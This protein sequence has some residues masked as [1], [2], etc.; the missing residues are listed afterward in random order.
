MSVYATILYIY[1]LYPSLS[2]S[3]WI[4]YDIMVATLGHMDNLLACFAFLKYYMRFDSINLYVKVLF[5]IH[6]HILEKKAVVL[7]TYSNFFNIVL[8]VLG[9]LTPSNASDIMY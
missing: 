6:F 1:L 2:D 3:L 7:A 9:P 4:M 8:P 5:I